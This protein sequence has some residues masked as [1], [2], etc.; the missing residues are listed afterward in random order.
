LHAL[1]GEHGALR[2]F[3]PLV[4]LPAQLVQ[5]GAVIGPCAAF[6]FLHAFELRLEVGQPRLRQ[7]PGSLLLN[8]G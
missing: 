8:Q 5:L 6:H 1:K 4:A 2:L 7:F 3:L